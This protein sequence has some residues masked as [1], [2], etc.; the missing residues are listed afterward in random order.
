[1]ITVK[2]PATSANCGMGF[3]VMGLALDWKAV[4]RFEKSGQL[5]ITGC[6][7]AYKGEDNLV[8]T[9]Y[10]A[11]CARLGKEPVPLKMEIESDIPDARGLGSSATCIVAGCA[12]AYAVHGLEPDKEEILKTAA[13]IEGHPDNI[14]PAIFGGLA[15]SV[16][17]ED[18]IWYRIAPLEGWHFLCV[19]P[20]HP[21][22]T[23]DAR[24]VL[25]DQISH[26]QAALQTGRAILFYE[27][28]KEKDQDLA[29]AM[30]QDVLH[31]PYRKNLIPSYGRVRQLCADVPFWISGSGPTMV[32]ASTS[33]K[34]LEQIRQQLPL[35]D[36]IL[37]VDRSGMEIRYE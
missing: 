15:V 20:D 33:Q 8:W 16:M 12:A 11:M 17:D 27:A 34:E 26:H 18:R 29:K 24:R 25:P 32:A 6:K 19:V 31:E 3:D 30:L 37:S 21:V 5:E 28:L 14:C 10:Q 36:T 4:F 22:H 2:V 9:S 13:A 23:K 35:F 7:D 1:M